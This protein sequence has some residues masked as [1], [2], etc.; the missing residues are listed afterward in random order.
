MPIWAQADVLVIG[1]TAMDELYYIP[2]L[3]EFIFWGTETSK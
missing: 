3:R 1:N 2:N